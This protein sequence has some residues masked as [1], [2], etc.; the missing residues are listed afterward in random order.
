[1]HPGLGKVE[2]DRVVHEEAGL[3]WCRTLDFP[4]PYPFIGDTCEKLTR[5]MPISSTV[6]SGAVWTP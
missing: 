6:A 2:D 1:L 3:P 5:T 4:V